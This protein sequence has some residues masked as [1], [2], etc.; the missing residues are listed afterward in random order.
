MKEHY[1]QAV[2]QM[3]N[4]GTAPETIL[5][6]L[7]KAM[8]QKGHMRLYPSV[9][10]GVL[11]ILETQKDADTIVVVAR[12]SDVSALSSQIESA[13]TTL[14][15]TEKPA[16]KVDETLVGGVVVQHGNTVL[17]RSFK[18]ALTKLYR[19]VTK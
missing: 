15:T 5:E 18:T 14:G 10:R 19:S 3:I 2:L 7:T 11:R 16:T 9:L 4:E 12:E 13:L 8:E 1:T 17:D 6:G